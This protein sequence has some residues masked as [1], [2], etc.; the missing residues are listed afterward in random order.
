MSGVAVDA[1][2]SR[3]RQGWRVAGYA[4]AAGIAF[5]VLEQIE[6]A[7]LDLVGAD[8][9]LAST[10]SEGADERLAAEA[11][12]LAA[13]SQA[14]MASLPSGHRSAAF[15]LGYELG[16]ASEFVGSF[17]MSD[18]GIQARATAIGDAHVAVARAAAQRIGIDDGIVAALPSRTLTDFARV[19]ERFERDESGIAARVE[20]QLT[21]VHRELYLFGVSVGADAAMVE[22]SSGKL[23]EPSVER[24]RRHATL[25]GIESAAW[26]PLV[27][28]SRGVPPDVVVARHRTAVEA[29]LSTLAARDAD[30]AARS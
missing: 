4:A 6:L 22:S 25:A 12:A 14:R 15:R 18:P 3:W 21:P 7:L 23:A 24:I 20:A 16:W 29:I 9:L 28:D 30:D 2:R 1:S 27:A 8:T 19:Q 13:R 11:D 17:A 10:Q 26:Q 5:V